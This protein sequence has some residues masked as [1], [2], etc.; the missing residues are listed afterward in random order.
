[1]KR[2]ADLQPRK[3]PIQG[4][5]RQTVDAIVEATARVL[6]E[7]GYDKASTNRIAKVAGVSIGSLY[8]YFAGKEALVLE[9]TRRHAERMLTL[10]A[11]QTGA[12]A[13]VPLPQAVRRYVQAMLAAHAMEPELHR[14]LATQAM[15]LAMQGLEDFEH[16]AHVIVR[17]ALEERRD[18]ILPDDLDVAAYVLVTAVES[19]AHRAALD[20][21]EYLAS[22]ALENEICAFVLRYLLGHAG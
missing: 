6:I 1:M 12:A 9:L 22:K 16:R 17:A 4:R 21:P 10:L 3:K 8:Q 11:E 14:V 18:E 15:R 5:S 7:E 13:A 20:H 2:S 19:V